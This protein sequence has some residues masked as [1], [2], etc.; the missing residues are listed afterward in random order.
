MP[1]ADANYKGRV[2]MGGLLQSGLG[3][4]RWIL[5]ALCLAA[6]GTDLLYAHQEPALIANARTL[7]AKG[8]LPEARDALEAELEVD[9]HAT[10]AHFLLGFIL[11][12]LQEPTRSLAEYT[13]G[14]AGRRPTAF[15]FR[16]IGADYVLLKDFADADRWFT[17]AT[18]ADPDD[19]SGW[20]LLG[21]AEYS[22][23]RYEEAISTFHRVLNI[24]PDDVKAEDNLG[25]SYQAL[26]Q[27]SEA[28]AA[29]EK[30][31]ATQRGKAIRSGAPYLDLGELLLQQ[32]EPSRATDYLLEAVRLSD[33]NPK[34]HEQLGIALKQT[35]DL[36]RARIELEKAVALAP[37]ASPV[38]FELGQIYR[39]LGLGEEAKHEFGLCSQLSA[40][41]SSEEV[42]NF[43]AA[44][45]LHDH[46]QSSNAPHHP[47]PD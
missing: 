1:A 27:V 13:N 45:E 33:K 24:T 44:P 8:D 30:A 14:A 28:R 22:E 17:Q 47:N 34:A 4:F 10:E 11:F 18:L 12:R 31:I 7:I 41:H 26:N 16:T 15:E 42:P 46:Q 21:R 6:S 43:D 32:G 19:P 29:F 25:L 39:S 37:K 3:L 23:G 5:A 35:G 9:P 2:D 20:Y 36:R 38:H 40:S